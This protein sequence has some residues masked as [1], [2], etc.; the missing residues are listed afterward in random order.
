MA[1]SL[2]A[3]PPRSPCRRRRPLVVAGREPSATPPAVTAQPAAIAAAGSM[4]SARGPPP[5][6]RP[7]AGMSVAFTAMGASEN[8]ASADVGGVVAPARG[9]GE[10]IADG[11]TAARVPGRG[12]S[13]VSAVRTRRSAGEAR[14]DG[15]LRD[16]PRR[17]GRGAGTAAPLDGAK[18]GRPP[19]ARCRSS[20]CWRMPR[21]HRLSLARTAFP[22][23][24]RPSRMGFRGRGPGNALPD[25]NTLRDFREALIAAGALD[26]P[27]ARMG[28]SI[29]E[30]G[31][32]P[33]A[34]PIVD[35]RLVAAS[36][37]RNGDAGKA[38]IEASEGARRDPAREA[39]QGTAEGR[40]R[41]LDGAVREGEVR[42]LP[43]A[44]DRHRHPDLRLQVAHPHRPTARRH[45]PG[46]GHRRH[47]A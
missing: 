38:R 9:T 4:P 8:R 2:P 32:L 15:G 44:A 47:G 33:M 26:A 16:L 40:R 28:P 10:G 14:R 27:F 25:A 36:R 1:P 39:R 35:A 5:A 20:G 17:T 12:A 3:P 24:D 31:S 45:P 30:A 11:G 42:R 34:G 37:Q 7:A 43:D 22:V 46:A 6:P 19:F 18:G 21:V 41:A 29:A 23:A 13:A